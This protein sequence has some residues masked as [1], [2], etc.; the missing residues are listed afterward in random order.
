MLNMRIDCIVG[1]IV[2][3]EL[4][5]K[6]RD[7]ALYINIDCR[8]GFYKVAGETYNQSRGL[9]LLYH[10]NPGYSYITVFS[11]VT[12]NPFGRIETVPYWKHEC[13][14]DVCWRDIAIFS[15]VYFQMAGEINARLKTNGQK[16]IAPIEMHESNSFAGFDKV[17]DWKKVQI[18]KDPNDPNN[19]RKMLKLL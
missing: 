9:H 3:Q 15:D 8:L 13:T 5:D 16:E 12:D 19:Y 14:H 6:G 1:Q 18:T 10:V 17:F 11:G 2:R 4:V 7:E